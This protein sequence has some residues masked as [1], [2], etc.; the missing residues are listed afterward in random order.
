MSL[1]RIKKEFMVCD[2]VVKNLAMYI[3]YI[4]TSKIMNT[5]KHIMNANMF[6]SA[7]TLLMIGNNR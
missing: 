4:H 2:S 1:N 3:V 6:M 7:I 5:V